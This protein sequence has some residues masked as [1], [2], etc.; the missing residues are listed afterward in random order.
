MK[1]KCIITVGLLLAA[2]AVGAEQRTK[3]FTP[4]EILK[5]ATSTNAE[6]LRF[7][8][9]RDPYKAA[10]LGVIEEGAWADMLIYNA[11]PLADA[12]VLTKPTEHLKLIVKG[13]KVYKNEL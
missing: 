3:F 5:Q 6:L 12:M 11:D 4:V 9:S 2:S 7:S 13:G 8:N 10:P 1:T